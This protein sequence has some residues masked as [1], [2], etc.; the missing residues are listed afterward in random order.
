VWIIWA[1]SRVYRE[2]E[3]LRTPVGYIPKY[4]DIKQLFKQIF[5]KHYSWEDYE[6]QF[7]I[8]VDKYLKKI[9]RMENTFR[10][11]SDMPKEFWQVLN[12]QKTELESIRRKTRKT[13]LSPTH[14][15]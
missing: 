11:E 12:K 8:R 7:S 9:S 1:E 13:V 5:N 2:Y 10:S 14:F 4:E 6:I 3:A 15:I